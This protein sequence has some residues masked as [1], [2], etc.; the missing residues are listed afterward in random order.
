MQADEIDT[1]TFLPNDD[2]ALLGAPCVRNEV[3]YECCPEPYI[4]VTCS[5]KLRRRSKGIWGQVIIPQNIFAF[6]FLLSS[7]IPVSEPTARTTVK[8]LMFL[9]VCV[10]TPKTLPSSSLLAMM[11]GLLHD[12]LLIILHSLTNKE[13]GGSKESPQRV[14]WLVDIS[15]AGTLMVAFI[16]AV[17]LNIL[18]APFLIVN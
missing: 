4:D 18:S 3:V 7:F 8:L 14:V 10:Y 2:W 9:L 15:V 17:L 11:L 16:L 12:V 13:K 1:S 5:L 6:I